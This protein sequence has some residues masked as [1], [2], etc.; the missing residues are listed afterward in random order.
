MPVLEIFQNR[1]FYC[2]ETNSASLDCKIV[3]SD[4]FFVILT[5]KNSLLTHFFAFLHPLTENLSLFTELAKK[6][7]K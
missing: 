6:L 4:T 7:T 5:M 2:C 1:H 3:L